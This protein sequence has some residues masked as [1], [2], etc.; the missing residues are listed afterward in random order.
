M[1]TGCYEEICRW[2]F[3]VFH[4]EKYSFGLHETAFLVKI[5]WVLEFVVTS[6][7]LS[8]SYICLKINIDYVGGKTLAGH[9]ADL[10][11]KWNEILSSMIG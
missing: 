5:V 10:M 8:V 11:I 3:R 7:A 2:H 1:F 4:D 6:I 9:L